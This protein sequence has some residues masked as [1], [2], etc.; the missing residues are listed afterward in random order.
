MK[1]R[2]FLTV[3]SV[4]SLLA[5]LVFSGCMEKAFPNDDLDFY[6]RLDRIDFKDGR[7]FQ[8]QECDY[9]TVDNIMFG[10]ARHIVL[11][12]APGLNQQHGITTEFQDSIRLDYSVYNNPTLAGQLQKCGLD[13][14]VSTF[15]LEFPDRGRMVLSGKKTILR[16]RKW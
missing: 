11:I 12:E 14:I 3:L 9:K 5:L 16:F 15:K 13:S 4:F 6:W 1:R 7:D 10:F 2:L 8:G